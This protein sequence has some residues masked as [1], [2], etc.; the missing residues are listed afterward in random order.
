MRNKPERQ[1]T[2][3][4]TESMCEREVVSLL[5]CPKAE[6]PVLSLSPLSLTHMCTNIHTLSPFIFQKYQNDMPYYGQANKTTKFKWIITMFYH[7]FLLHQELRVVRK[8]V[9]SY[10]MPF[11]LIFYQVT[12]IS[13]KD[14]SKAPS[15]Y[16]QT[17]G[18]DWVMPPLQ[19]KTMYLVYNTCMWLPYCWQFSDLLGEKKTTCTLNK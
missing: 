16:S 4:H 11:L 2:L 17:D 19:N 6:S 1:E 7:C 9:A 12:P 13:V 5:C 3:G 8:Y 14:I 10:S 18:M 15:E